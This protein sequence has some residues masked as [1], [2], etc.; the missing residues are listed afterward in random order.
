MLKCQ[1]KKAIQLAKRVFGRT[2]RNF[3]NSDGYL[4]HRKAIIMAQGG[5]KKD[6]FQLVLRDLDFC[7]NLP[8]SLGDMFGQQVIRV[9]Q[10]GKLW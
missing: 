4:H 1:Q 3:S 2:T 7:L 6:N 10:A 8:F 5:K 9:S